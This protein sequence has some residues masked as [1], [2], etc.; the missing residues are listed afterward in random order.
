MYV[1]TQ[2]SPS[3]LGYYIRGRRSPAN[4]GYFRPNLAIRQGFLPGVSLGDDLST[5]PVNMPL[6]L[7]GVA[8]LGLG[9]FLFGRKRGAI[10]KR[11][12]RRRA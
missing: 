3:N 1:Y 4:L 10:S 7:G 2:R 11:R 9:L 12:R 8:A 6:M 5:I